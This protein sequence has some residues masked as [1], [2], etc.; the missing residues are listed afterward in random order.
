MRRSLWTWAL[1]A[2]SAVGSAYATADAP[3]DGVR[4]PR[5]SVSGVM[6]RAD[7]RGRPVFVWC[8]KGYPCPPVGLPPI[9]R[10]APAPCR[11]LA[12]VR[13]AFDSADLT[14][15]ARRVLDGL[16]GSG[17]VSVSGYTD[18]IGS[19]AYN[20]RLARA[21]AMAVAAH[22]RA[23]GVRVDRVEGR[24][25]CCYVASPRDARNRRAEIHAGGDVCVR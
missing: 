4:I 20:D 12:V 21:R 14:P 18:A 13:F 19:K 5:L 9:A 25:K 10:R 2:C 24:G 15:A 22:L 11:R 3:E 16:R 7:A 1:I 6:Q 8:G 17:P 23:I